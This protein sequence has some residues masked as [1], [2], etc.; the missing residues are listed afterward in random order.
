MDR[1]FDEELVALKGQIIKMSGIAESMVQEVFRS[2]FEH[3]MSQFET[4]RQNE[5]LVNRMQMEI[6]EHVLRLIA[7]HQPTASD[8]RFLMGVSKINA[9]LERVGDHAISITHRVSRV[10]EQEAIKPFVDMP[11]MAEM[12][13]SMFKESLNA[14]ATLDVDAAHHILYRDDQVNRLR[15]TIVNELVEMMEKNSSSVKVATSLILIANN[16][17]KIADHATNI[18]EVVVFVAQG[19]DIRHHAH[20]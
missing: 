1:H 14:F 5:A 12:A 4:I 8:L 9:E 3:D 11:R 17:E 13:R 19:K 18:S 10:L 7:L 2:L 6:D 20:A 16:I 15:D